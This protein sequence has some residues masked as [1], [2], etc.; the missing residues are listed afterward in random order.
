MMR[1]KIKQI[2]QETADTRTFLFDVAPYSWKYK[3]GQYVTLT[4]VVEKKRFYRSYSLASSPDCDPLP[5]ITVKRVAHGL[6]SNYL[7]DHL[8]VG[9]ELTCSLPRGKFVINHARGARQHV[10]IAAGSGIV[11]LF[12][13]IKSMLHR[14]SHSKATLIYTNRNE[15]SIIYQQ[16]LS[17]LQ[18]QYPKRLAIV[19]ILTRPHGSSWQGMQGRLTAERLQTMIQDKTD[20]YYWL[21][22]PQGLMDVVYSTLFLAGVNSKNIHQEAFTS[23]PTLTQENIYKSAEVTVYHQGKTHTLTLKK[24]EKILDTMLDAGFDVPFSCCSGICNTCRV[25]CVAGKV[26]MLDEE[27]LSKKEKAQGYILSCVA[28]PRTD[29][30]TIDLDDAS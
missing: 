18:A 2:I 19:H 20:A 3:A 17:N 16:R 25:K 27:G 14:E 7:H 24:G 1:V 28:Y 6:V 29:K 12:A 9:S 11:P 15:A 21:C 13:M 10:F 5:A 22:A 8:S 23:P 30:L 4:L 26:H